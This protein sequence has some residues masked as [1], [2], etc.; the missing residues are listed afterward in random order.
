MN[1]SIIKQLALAGTLMGNSMHGEICGICEKVHH[2]TKNQDCKLCQ[3]CIEKHNIPLDFETNLDG[4]QGFITHLK[5]DENWQ[6]IAAMYKFNPISVDE[7]TIEFF[8]NIQ[9]LHLY[10]PED[11]YELPGILKKR[12]EMWDKKYKTLKEEYANKKIAGE[13][14]QTDYNEKIAEL[15]WQNQY[16]MSSLSASEL[17]EKT[18]RGCSDASWQYEVF[19][20]QI[21]AWFDRNDIEVTLRPALC[22]QDK[23]AVVFK[24]SID[25]YTP[26][27][28]VIDD[29]R[30]RIDVTYEGYFKRF[31][32]YPRFL[33]GECFS[34]D[35]LG[36][37]YGCDWLNDYYKP[38]YKLY[39]HVPKSVTFWAVN[40]AVYDN[41]SYCLVFENRQH[42][43]NLKRAIFLADMPAGTLRISEIIIKNGNQE[44]SL[45]YKKE[46]VDNQELIQEWANQVSIV[47]KPSTL[48]GYFEN[49][50]D[51]FFFSPEEACAYGSID[52]SS[53]TIEN[54]PLSINK[55]KYL[56][57]V[58]PYILTNITASELECIVMPNCRSCYIEPN[59]FKNCLKLKKLVLN[60][61]YNYYSHLKPRLDAS[62]L[63]D[64]VEICIQNSSKRFVYEKP[65]Q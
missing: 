41:G 44:I 31:A 50:D 58:D 25:E 29:N 8:S 21:I 61:N 1:K 28:V 42:Y 23:H 32:A 2:D 3:D 7:N 40:K 12:K 51:I 63:K 35:S 62:G 48:K 17:K 26:C 36:D 64:G 5:E 4:I 53:K 9:T 54:S 6:G 59:V 38:K 18:G 16:I 56:W 37:F 20:K 39:I 30:K 10:K 49:E 60:W 19:F 46:R 22:I 33:D 55:V 13:L 27:D 65:N 57:I 15:D 11:A 52:M 24:G 45:D 43:E 47:K 34:D 14:T